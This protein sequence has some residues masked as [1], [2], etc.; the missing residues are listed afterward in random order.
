MRANEKHEDCIARKGCGSPLV[1]RLWM[2]CGG[3]LAWRVEHR[4]VIN[5]WGALIRRVE[6]RFNL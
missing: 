5:L 4:L 1:D 3:H 6:N 2:R